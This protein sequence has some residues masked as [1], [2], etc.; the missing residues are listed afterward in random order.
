MFRITRVI[1]PLAAIVTV[2][3]CDVPQTASQESPEGLGSVVFFHPDGM[4]VN[5]WGAVRVMTVGP[6]GRLNGVIRER[7]GMVLRL[8]PDASP[9]EL[10]ES[11]TQNLR[12]LARLG[13]TSIIQA[14][15]TPA[16]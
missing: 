10:A 3:A 1:V 5:T 12:D 4:G 8:V 7:A 16:G 9:E 14:G 2:T 6:D 15:E 13:I 11:L